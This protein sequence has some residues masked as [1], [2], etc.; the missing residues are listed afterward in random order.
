LGLSCFGEDA[1]YTF[2]LPGREGV[3]EWV[4]TYR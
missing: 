3:R 1:T 2:F 4:G